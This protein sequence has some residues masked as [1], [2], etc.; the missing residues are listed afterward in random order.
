MHF[1]ALLLV[2][3]SQA[4]AA[5]ET[6]PFTNWKPFHKQ[7]IK[8]IVYTPSHTSKKQFLHPPHVKIMYETLLTVHV[9]H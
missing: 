3:I 8:E 6:R 4:E 5:L 7:N 1:V 9:R 2:T